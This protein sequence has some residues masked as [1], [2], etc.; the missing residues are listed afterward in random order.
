M[1]KVA[2]ITGASSGIG[3]ALANELAESGYELALAARRRELLDE[4]SSRIR[5]AGGTALPLACDVGDQAQV[6]AAVSETMRNFGRIDLAILSAGIGESTNAINFRADKF[7]RLLRTNVLGV[8]LCLEELIPV[9]RAQQQGVIAAISSLAGDRGFPGSAGYCATK[10]ALSTLFDGLRG[11]LS[12]QGVRLVT[13]EPGYVQTPMTASFG[14]MPFLQ[15][16]DEA[17]RLILRRIERGDRV[18]RFPFV[19]SVFMKLMQILPVTFFDI[20]TAKRRPVRLDA[21]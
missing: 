13:V 18:I 16:A 3:H 6:R 9:M 5:Q 21:D 7:E 19:P 14:K 4:I 2:F 20:L 17:A 11:E 15:P 12:R 8:A 1:K 10:A